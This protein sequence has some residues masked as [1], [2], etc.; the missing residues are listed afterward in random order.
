MSGKRII[1]VGGRVIDPANNV[2]G[3]LDVEIKNGKISQIGE[4]LSTTF[5]GEEVSRIDAHGCIVTPGVDLIFVDTHNNF[6]RFNAIL[7][8][9]TYK[10][11]KQRV[12]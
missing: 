2:D 10:H 6:D 7:I 1:I 4:N 12:K 3:I 8:F 5:D 11:K 9:W